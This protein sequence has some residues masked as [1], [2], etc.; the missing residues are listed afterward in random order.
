MTLSISHRL[1]S[2]AIMAVFAILLLVGVHWS[3]EGDLYIADVIIAVIAMIAL[4]VYAAYT[5]HNVATPIRNFADVVGKIADGNADV[6]V[7]DLDRQD[8]IGDLARAAQR[9]KEMISVRSRLT[10]A[11]DYTSANVMIADGD[12]NIVYMNRAATLMM[13][14]AEDDLRKELR[15]FDVDNIIGSNIDAFHKNPSHQQRLVASLNT[16]YT[17][18]ISVGIRH[19]NLIAN[20]ILDR[21]NRRIGTVVEWTDITEKVNREK[22]EQERK[23]IEEKIAADNLRIK[24]A[25]DNVTTNVLLADNEGNI[26]YAN[27]AV[28]AML[29]HA[30][31][32]VQKGLSNFEADKV[33]GSN[34]DIFHS[35][36]SH[37]RAL[38]KRLTQTYKSEITVGEASFVLIANPVINAEGERF[39]T[40][41]EWTD[42]TEKV[43]REK[44]EQERKAIE[45]KIAADNLRIKVALDNV[46][47]NVLLADNEGNIIY[48]NKAVLAML[49]HAEEAVQ[50][51]LPSFEADK[52]LG[53]NFDIFHSDPSHQRVLLDRLTQTYKSQITVGDASFV[54]IANPVI[55]AEGERLGSVVE[56]S[57]ITQELAVQE[58]VAEIVTGAMAGDFTQRIGLEDKHGFM[59]QLSEHINTLLQ[60]TSLAIE[61]LG[62]MMAALAKG[63]LSRR[64][65]KDYA[66]SFQQLK[67]DSNVM[68]DQ[69]TDIVNKI[70]SNTTLVTSA[71]SEIADG[72]A[73]LSER[74]EQQAANLEET[75]ASMEEL[76]ATV[77]QNSENAQQANQLAANARKVAEKGGDVVSQAVS[78]MS[79][80]SRSSQKISD[81]IGVIDEI[82]FQTNLLA[83]NAAVEA[84]RAGEAG[85]GFAV[86]ASEVRTLAQR[87]AQA[88]KEIKSLIVDS[89]S[90]VKDGVELVN[91]TGETLSE[92]VNSVKRVADIVSEIAAAS[93]EQAEGLEQVNTAITQM[94]EMTQK[95]AAL[96]EESAAAAR[97]L[98]QQ[99]SELTTQI[100]FFSGQSESIQALPAVLPER[101]PSPQKP[102]L[103]S[104]RAVQEYS[105]PK[106]SYDHSGFE[107][108]SDW[109]EF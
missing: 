21:K 82:A 48:A 44:E 86:V 96:V 102:I 30:E 14:D 3:G 106:T 58:E 70:S 67:L 36:P 41:V 66:G 28:L 38:L 91:N 12:N 71:S 76:A 57:N 105:M 104:A 51:G 15:N 23:A 46:T 31:D 93:T 35:D 4:P 42:I 62:E 17:A 85:K 43:N 24:V 84:A 50:K 39:G 89:G 10:Q 13:R 37:Q 83:L 47:T 19:F 97:S 55:N 100:G 5:A 34:F 79:N 94:D 64:I 32:A 6:D 16:T 72:S 27:K 7:K 40:V 81:I 20:P 8:E 69:L 56:W 103:D 53:S 77:R 75:A 52:V 2:V 18:E 95:N 101:S 98:E 92:I 9:L 45:E 54:L 29:K 61:D 87:S 49:K 26:I 90:Q 73:D 59:R 65:E 25:L 11:L 63:D 22:E 1:Y 80:I 88:S 68:A 108:D 99:A 78:A 74:T 109:K 60:T 33:L 107:D